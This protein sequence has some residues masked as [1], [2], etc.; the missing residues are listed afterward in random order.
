LICDQNVMI[1]IC[2]VVA[3]DA[4]IFGV[5]EIWGRVKGVAIFGLKESHHFPGSYEYVLMTHKVYKCK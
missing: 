3:W 2:D 4:M 5:C 1:E